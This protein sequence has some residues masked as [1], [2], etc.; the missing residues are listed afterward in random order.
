MTGPYKEDGSGTLWSPNKEDNP[1]EA[2]QFVESLKESIKP[3][4][5]DDQWLGNYNTGSFE[6]KE[7][8]VDSHKGT[9]LEITGSIEDIFIDLH[10]PIKNTSEMQKIAKE[11][12]KVVTI[13]KESS[14]LYLKPNDFSEIRRKTADGQGRVNLGKEKAGEE[15]RL[16]VLDE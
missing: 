10:I 7:M 3:E 9:S 5:Q 12:N 16:V 15:V 13:D 6:L 11:I 4:N 14:G 8:Y 2:K 1:K